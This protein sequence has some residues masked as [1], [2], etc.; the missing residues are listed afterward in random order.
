MQLIYG[1]YVR[2]VK[3]LAT[4]DYQVGKKKNLG[5]ECMGTVKSWNGDE[6]FMLQE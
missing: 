5:F 2:S 3:I 4:Q 1:Q 6:V